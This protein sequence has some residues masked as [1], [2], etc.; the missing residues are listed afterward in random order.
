MGISVAT[1]KIVNKKRQPRNTEAAF[2]GK[3]F[4]YPSGC[5]LLYFSINSSW[6]SL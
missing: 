1:F 2:V 3:T 4:N 6:V 5:N